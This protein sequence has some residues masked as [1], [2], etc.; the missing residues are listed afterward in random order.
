MALINVNRLS[1]RNL[2][3]INLN[4]KNDNT[5]AYNNNN[6]ENN[7]TNKNNTSNA[8]LQISHAKKT[9]SLLRNSRKS[10]PVIHFDY[11]L[12]VSHSSARDSGLSSHSS[13]SVN[14]SPNSTQLFSKAVNTATCQLNLSPTSLPTPLPPPVPEHAPHSQAKIALARRKEGGK[15]RLRSSKSII[16][17]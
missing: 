8:D 10:L 12:E 11:D 3:L 14:Y 6:N 7:D 16:C 5:I 4:N 15:T 9:K 1:T 17:L 2:N 13:N